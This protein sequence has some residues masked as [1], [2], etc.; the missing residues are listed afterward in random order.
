MNTVRC[1]HSEEEGI[2]AGAHWKEIYESESVTQK[3][4]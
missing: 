2:C 3:Q 4:A 1:G